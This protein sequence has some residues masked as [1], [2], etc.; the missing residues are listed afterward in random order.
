MADPL[1]PNP[2]DAEGP[3]GWI[4]SQQRAAQGTALQGLDATPDDGAR[5]IELSKA[6]GADPAVVYGD[7]DRF[8]Q[9][10]KAS[11]T[12]QLLSNNQFLR[13]YANSHP[14]AG[15]VSSDDWG[16]LDSL[17][18]SLQ[19]LPKI[20]AGKKLGSIIGA[21]IEDFRT[22]FGE[23]PLGSAYMQ[24]PKTFEE[25][26]RLAQ[27]HPA[28]AMLAAFT[29]M[30]GLIPE[31]FL[32]TMSGAMAGAAGMVGE[33]FKQMGGDPAKVDE[34][35]E[36]F[37]Q[38]A[39]DPGLW[40]SLGPAGEAIGMPFELMAHNAAIGKMVKEAAN[41]AKVAAPF[42]K[43]G[44]EPP[45]GLHPLIDQAKAEQAKL[46]MKNLDEAVKE[47]G[48]SATKERAPE[49]FEDFIRQHTD[50]KIGID[51]EAVRKL[52]G[53]KEPEAG[54]G[55]LGDI[56]GMAD[57][58][59]LAEAHGGD[60][61]V[62][63]ATWIA[64]IEPEIAK[65]LHD[66][67]RVRPGGM[68][69]EEAKGPK[70]EVE[71]PKEEEG[72]PAP[73]VT[74]VDSLRQTA[75]LSP[76]LQE[77]PKG[78]DT[79]G[80]SE[81]GPSFIPDSSTI[82]TKI[83][84]DDGT[85][86]TASHSFLAGD[87]L[88]KIDPESL[89]PLPKEIFTFLGPKLDKLAGN[90]TVHVLNKEDMAKLSERLS[91]K[92]DA[93]GM[94]VMWGEGY[95]EIFLRED[96]AS[97]RLGESAS[98]H[99]IVH[100]IAHGA[101]VRAMNNN[102]VLQKAIIALAKETYDQIS[103]A[104]RKSHNYAFFGGDKT[105]ANFNPAEFIAEAFSKQS[106]QEVLASSKMSPELAKAL[107]LD[108]GPK[109][110]WDAFRDM[111]RGVLEKIIGKK[112]PTTILDGVLQIGKVIEGLK[113]KESVSETLA[114]A[115]ESRDELEAANDPNALARQHAPTY[116]GAMEHQT[117][118]REVN[119][120]TKI[121]DWEYWRKVATE[122][123][124]LVNGRPNP[125]A[126]ARANSQGGRTTLMIRQD[127][128]RML[129]R[130][131]EKV[132]AERIVHSAPP[133]FD[134]PA[135][136]GMNKERAERYRKLIEKQQEEDA[137]FQSEQGLAVERERQ[138]KEWK[139]NEGRVRQ[140]VTEDL[141]SRPDLAADRFLR[142]GELYGEKHKAVKIDGQALTPE[143]RKALPQD[144]IGK[145][146]IAPDDLAGLFGYSSGD[147]LVAGL[148]RLEAERQMEGL[149]PQAHFTRLIDAETDRQMRK[150]YGDLEK[151][152]IEEA[153]EHVL[154]P[155]Q[156][157]ILHEEMLALG[158]KAGGPK[159]GAISKD[160][161]K[162]WTKA[163]FDKSPLAAHDSD[164]YMAAAGR[165]G[166]AAEDALLA[167]KPTDAYKA[168]QQQVIAIHLAGMAKKLE[169]EQASYEKLAK[170]YSKREISGVPAEY[171]NWIHDIL[172]RTGTTVRRSVNDLQDAIGREVHS[173]LEKFVEEKNYDARIWEVDNDSPSDFQ[174]MP[175]APFLYDPAYRKP[176]EEMTP[177]EFRAVHNSIKTLVKNGQDEKK[178]IV[179][180]EKEDLA[181]TIGK[182]T[183]QL[184]TLFAG[185]ERQYA[186]GHKDEG[187][188]HAVRTYWAS[189]LQ[190]ESIFNRFDRGDPKGIFRKV[191]TQPIFEGSHDLNTLETKYAR[192]YKALSFKDEEMKKR[193]DNPLFGDPLRDG[194]KGPMTR[195]NLLA[196]LQNVGNEGQLD[197]LARGYGIK[198]KNAIMQW[199]FA[200]T[201]KE[202][203]DRAQ[204]L[205]D[206]FEK[207]FDE[208][209]TMYHNLSGVAPEKIDIQPIQTPF[210]EY[211]GW[212][213]PII[214]DPLRPG[215]SKKLMGPSPLEDGSYYR[216][217][218]PSGYTKR[219][220]G[221]AAPIQLNFDAIPNR[222][223]S[224]LN[225]IAMRPAM[226]EVAKVFYDRDFQMAMTK[227]YPKEIKDL[228]IPYLKDI[229]G[230]KTFKDAA[231]STAQRYLEYARQNITA[232]L[233]GLNPSTVLKHGPTAAMLSIKEVGALPFLR[234]LK[235][236]LSYN[237]DLGE[238]NWSFA[239]KGGEVNGQPW[240]G[241]EELQR[242]H[243]NWQETL[244]GAQADVF[245]ENTLRN[246]VIKLGA[247]P[248]AISDLLSAVPTWLAAYKDQI[249]SGESHGDSVAFADT[250]V[251]RAHG[252]SAVAARPRIMRGGA[253]AQLA[254]PFYTFF[255]EMFQRQ[256]EMAWRAKDALGQFSE[257]EYRAGLK[258]VPNLAKG[259]WAYVVFP[260]LIE[261]AVSPLITGQESTGEK[262]LTY[263]V[264][265]LAS[266]LPVLRDMVEAFLGGRDPTVGL[267]STG[268]KMLVDSVKDIS[269]GEVSFNKAH[270]GKTI[271]HTVTAFGAVTG[272]TNAQEGRT[273]EFVY[274]YATGKERPKDA[275]EILRGLWHGTI[276]EPTR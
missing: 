98:A 247:T 92:P 64:K 246:T 239:M 125:V 200:N 197:K 16:Q 236:L 223:K 179:R 174:V 259:L 183:S 261:Q 66:F 206:I 21:G 32:R 161:I 114:S 254:T 187:F 52:Y 214:Y 33:A 9:Q 26:Q 93:P 84:L 17:S 133:I 208:S 1:F 131:G 140:E 54:D 61:E 51:A 94:H 83:E 274:N 53:D 89:D 67:V 192:M 195:G 110:M 144:Y 251:R 13:D 170:R 72:V 42:V 250:A 24:T 119:K 231:Q 70:A 59:R 73:E 178:I 147:A 268:T 143:Q 149:T 139:E 65:E 150:T 173:A 5:A 260:A 41:V 37:L 104:D 194:E 257:G 108:T 151:N 204:A 81:Q 111:V 212:Y 160:D 123:S 49:L 122:E 252:S 38:V 229:A 80:L 211:R 78:W 10:H 74:P 35:K 141:K 201:K 8:E 138:T 40:A 237:D 96:I 77:A 60:V 169:K 171:T 156:M 71:K 130:G 116:K 152:I 126:A 7:L 134:R 136:L 85:K 238:R 182:M 220:T 240:A 107:H 235:G 44:V 127:G 242:R 105:K 199:L 224:M 99:I 253:L 217:A 163:E 142:M 36:H 273:G 22:A 172:M 219:R 196:V 215:S 11:L 34:T 48:S 91:G 4:V 146:G 225:D 154:S 6:T 226:T 184:A 69:L 230:Q 100:E 191:V 148:G 177:P 87:I 275:R 168:K 76:K 222:L 50:A 190:I 145:E 227:Y 102:P 245:G 39:G 193:V 185:K 20:Q 198:D 18:Q 205:G 175:V 88:S 57:Q 23:G 243:R 203:W 3:A 248:V 46:D 30:E 209:A 176:V 181:E 162:A 135:A 269:K 159:A 62:P 270:A 213:H 121:G 101:T 249:R 221:Y 218:T 164:K 55:I 267:Y 241:S 276:K 228:L 97:G 157:D 132:V 137:K 112:I 82:G 263:G 25:T 103:D 155:T 75:G 264:R 153:K 186:F 106:F 19:R 14:L 216:A 68:T 12:S 28:G 29:A 272:L 189:L 258:E 210:G 232:T 233:I 256:Y 180:G 79:V 165:A 27:E 47:A 124:H 255:N 63:L 207:A 15:V 113:D 244:T 128:R 2:S 56:P 109:T 202:D 271:R 115:A 31:T 265:T 266:S 188:K 262:A 158:E 90:V 120:E 234:E 43:E 45:V 95:N 118:K 86:V 58:L 117:I 167:D 166:Q 129:F